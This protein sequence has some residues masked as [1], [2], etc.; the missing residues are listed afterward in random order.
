MKK[1]HFI[2]TLL[3]GLL[4][5]L[6][7]HNCAGQ[8]VTLL[9]GAESCK[10]GGSINDEAESNGGTAEGP[11]FNGQYR[12]TSQDNS[13]A[14]AY[15]RASFSPGDVDF[16]TVKAS[17]GVSLSPGQNAGQPSQMS[18]G[19]ASCYYLL[20]AKNAVNYTLTA[21][22]SGNIALEVNFNGTSMLT[23]PGSLDVDGSFP[24]GAIFSITCGAD[25][26]N[27]QIGGGGSFA[28]NLQLM[29]ATVK[30]R[31]NSL[32][33]AS[34]YAQYLAMS[35]N[36]MANM[37]QAESYLETS[38]VREAIAGIAADQA[39][40]AQNCYNMFLDPVDT[41][42]TALVQ[43]A[44]PTVVP[45][46]VGN[47]I[48]QAEAVAYN[49]W[50]TNMSQEVGYSTALITAVNRAQGAAAYSNSYW[51]LRQMTS[52]VQFEAQLAA[53]A[54]SE[55]A[56]RSNVVAQFLAD[57]YSAFTTTAAQALAFQMEVLTNGLPADLLQALMSL[58][59]GGD[60]ITNIQTDILV[61]NPTNMAG[62]FPTS[63]INPNL[64]AAQ[65]G[66]AGNLRT[67]SLTLINAA[68]LPGGQF[69]F[70]LPTEPA[71][72]YR[73]QFSHDPANPSGWTTLLLTNATTSLLSFT[74]T[75]TAGPQAGFYRAAQ[76]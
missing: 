10:A 71:Y 72:T 60:S 40:T 37:L 29:P 5:F 4:T 42:F 2:P 49:A 14:F 24:A 61:A 59:L 45:L 44:F 25:N 15:L 58:G 26:N 48:T 33:K 12:F 20:E 57:G 51:D 11:G 13:A 43:A 68:L 55:P 28:L 1:R 27:N 46:L 54:D 62:S 76:N 17:G 69:R 3:A 21:E 6:A 73:I 22:V 52:A 47:G 35:A 30:P 34:F 39:A 36:S 19:Q 63:L 67:A 50:Q 8:A 74:N 70:D 41:N 31:L 66:L 16:A 7:C 9:S 32:Q 65:T 64:D 38:A 56:L 23:G 53:A 18:K 75:S